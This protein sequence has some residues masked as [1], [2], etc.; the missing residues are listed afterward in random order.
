[1]TVLYTVR[2][3][4]EPIDA[5]VLIDAG[6]PLF[7]GDPTPHVF[8]RMSFASGD[9]IALSE[10]RLGCHVGTHVDMPSH[11][12]SAGA[13]LDDFAA[14][15]L[16][17]RVHVLDCVSVT[18][19]V[20]ATDIHTAGILPGDHIVLRTANTLS[21]IDGPFR[22]DYVSVA[23][24]AVGKLVDS[25]ATVLG[26]DY[27]S[28]DRVSDEHLPA[29]RLAAERNVPVVVMLDLRDVA[30][31]SYFWVVAPLRVR[32]VEGAPSR[33]LFFPAEFE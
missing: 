11:F 4:G 6:M 18:G 23:A 33:V 8:Q 1:M 3:L 28:L 13:C 24:T 21:G 14:G 32:G 2:L 7:P 16:S 12:L 26:F 29:H 20:Q 17:G 27:Y 5:T 22:E 9:P 25:G 10:L 15:Q 19:S 30:P 31:G